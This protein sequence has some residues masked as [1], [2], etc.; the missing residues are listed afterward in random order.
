SII[1]TSGTTGQPKGVMLT[2]LNIISDGKAFLDSGIINRSD[3]MICVLPLYH[4][5]AF[6]VNFFISITY[7]LTFN[8]PIAL[9][10]RELLRSIKE[11]RTTV[12]VAVP[13]IFEM[14]LHEIDNKIDALP[15]PQ[16]MIALGLKIVSGNI[17]KRI[18]LN[19]GKKFFSS[20]HDEFGSQF[21]FS[22]SGGAKLMPE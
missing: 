3:S 14:L 13:R 18:G 17:R 1:F 4:T 6:T 12:L 22:F 16:R 19:I 21:R 9:K 20:I 10:G 7:G 8:F 15:F 5:Y 11:T 2:H